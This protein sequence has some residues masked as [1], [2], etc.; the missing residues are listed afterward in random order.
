MTV[1][2]AKKRARVRRSRVPLG[3]V[4]RGAGGEVEMIEFSEYRRNPLAPT[5]FV[6]R[7]AAIY[8]VNP[9]IIKVTFALATPGPAGAVDTSEIVSLV[10]ENRDW[11]DAGDLFRWAYTEIRRGTFQGALPDDG[12]GRRPRTQ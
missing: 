10:W 5:F 12:G 9:N 8:R 11:H 1:A 2:E 6:N 7:P 3:D 4:R